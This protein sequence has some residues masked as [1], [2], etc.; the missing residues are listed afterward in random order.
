MARIK[1]DQERKATMPFR[2][3]QIS[4]AARSLDTT[5]LA[6]EMRGEWTEI[7]I[8]QGEDA[9]YL[10]KLSTKEIYRAYMGQQGELAKKKRAEEEEKARQKFRKAIALSKRTYE[11]R[12]V[13]MDF[14]KAIEEER[15]KKTNQ[16]KR[17]ST[18]E[19]ERKQKKPRI[20][21]LVHPPS[22]QLIPSPRLHS[23]TPKESKSSHP[24]PSQPQPPK[25]KTKSPTS[26]SDSRKIVQ[27]FYSD[28]NEWYE[29]FRGEL[30]K[31]RTI[32]IY[33]DEVIQLPDFDLQRIFELGEAHEP[34]NESG[35][36]ILLIIKHH[37]NPIKEVVIDAKPTQAYFPIVKWSYNAA[38]DEY[39][40]V[41]VKGNK[42]RCTNKAIFNM[43]RGDIKSLFEIPFDNPSKD[44]RGYETTRIILNMQKLYDQRQ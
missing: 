4:R 24:S 37:F 16:T 36:H 12:K 44:P 5:K 7:L 32:C 23:S 42:M 9:D 41:D 10:E 8:S 19:D 33:V 18:T 31:K 35:R 43:P 3:Q 11:E 17:A 38:N 2:E 15:L 30:E 40:P 26:S 1:K 14:L 20:D 13:T 21:S 29:V 34:D 28:S 6:K 22:I 27:W 39:T 25:K